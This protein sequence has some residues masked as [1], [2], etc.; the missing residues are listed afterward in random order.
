MNKDIKKYHKI[1]VGLFSLFLIMA[2]GWR[3]IG[4]RTYYSEMGT[5]MVVV[6][7]SGV[8]VVGVSRSDDSLIWVD[9]PDNLKV[10]GYPVVSAWELGGID[11]SSE[12]LVI[13]NLGEGLGLWFQV[14]VRVDGEVTVENLLDRLLSLK[15][16][17]SLNWL[18]RYILYKDL[19]YLSGKGVV[20]ETNLPY[21]VMD[22]IQDVD[23]YGWLEL[24][25][26]V[27]VW[28]KDLW[29]KTEVVNLGIKADVV[30]ISD[31]PGTARVRA[32][33]LESVGFRVIGVSASQME[34]DGPCL[35]KVKPDV[36][37]ENKFM[38]QVIEDYL[39]CSTKVD[40]GLDDFFGDVVFFVG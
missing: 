33:Q 25:E 24:N 28:S 32:R 8:A 35:V 19:S 23:G 9:L 12:G 11:G 34:I 15:N 31:T 29:P 3:I 38:I 7:E 39:G 17:K 22:R 18:D 4:N 6:G 20:L 16:I 21:Q 2:I 14:A 37:G 10:D 13:E 36:V 40:S 30:N 1:L 27:F 26:A 5:N